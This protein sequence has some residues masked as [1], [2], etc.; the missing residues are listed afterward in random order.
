M[1]APQWTPR[2]QGGPPEFL[3]ALDI[4]APGPQRRLTV[5][6]R[7]LLLLP[8]FI[9]LALLG[10]AVFFTVIVGWFAALFTG[11]LP[12][13]IARFLSGFLAYDTRVS[14]AAMLLVDRYPPFAFYPADPYPTR[15]EL[16]PGPL[17]RLAVLFRIFLMIPAAIIRYLLEWG[18]SV[19]AVFI[20]LIVLVLGRMPRPIFEA[21][22]AVLRYGLRF[23]AYTL[24]VTSA[25]PKQL[26]G[27]PPEELPAVAAAPGAGG[28]EDTARPGGQGWP[29]PMSATRPL[30]MSGAAQ[31][32]VAVFLVLGLAASIVSDTTHGDDDHHGPRH[33]TPSPTVRR[34]DAG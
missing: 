9:V 5:L 2:A 33:T 10:I 12:E 34:V 28:P 18:W 6:L 15:I 16:R 13:G 23:E 31:A 22:A 32:L 3:P 7:W 29:F 17:N 26:F 27:D 14:A 19:L 4:P 24:M 20:W 30:V 11:R 1:A 21:T 25:Y 8:Q